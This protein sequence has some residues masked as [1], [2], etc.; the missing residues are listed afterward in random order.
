MVK[1]DERGQVLP[2]CVA[3]DH[4]QGGPLL[5]LFALL[6]RLYLPVDGSGAL[7]DLCPQLV[8]FIKVGPDGVH[9]AVFHGLLRS[10]QPFVAVIHQ[11]PVLF[12]VADLVAGIN[13]AGVAGQ[14][15]IDVLLHFIQIHLGPGD[16]R[17]FDPDGNKVSGHGQPSFSIFL[18]DAA[19]ST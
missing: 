5:G 2:R 18:W 19:G 6:Y 15:R 3:V 10:G 13:A 9:V 1:G 4:L 11:G 7:L 14:Q 8:D 16:I 12:G 17:Q